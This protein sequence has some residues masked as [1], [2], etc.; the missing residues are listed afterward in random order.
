MTGALDVEAVAVRVAQALETVGV[1]YALGGSVATSMQ[2]EPRSTND[3]DFA[4]RLDASQVPAL[5]A[6]LDHSYLEQWAPQLGV[7]DLLTRAR[8]TP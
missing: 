6:A 3:I 8:A 4:V 2:G 1:E 7:E 5:V